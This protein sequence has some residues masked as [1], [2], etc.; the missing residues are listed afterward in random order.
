VRVAIDDFGAGYSSLG[1]LRRLPFDTLKLDRSLMADLYT[2][3]GAQGVTTAVIA[4]ARSLNVRSVAEGVEDAAT[5]EMLAA[6]GCDEVQGHHVSPPLGP[7]DFEDWIE[8]GGAL[9]LAPASPLDVV[10]A[11]EA[12]ERRALAS[13]RG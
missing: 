11:L 5:L 1:Q 2:D 10:N 8:D 12:V 9:R 3:L 7:R 13:R 4:M 6:L